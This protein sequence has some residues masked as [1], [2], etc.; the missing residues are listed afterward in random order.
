MTRSA[1]FIDEVQLRTIAAEPT[2]DPIP[3]AVVEDERVTPVV[4]QLTQNFPNPFNAHTSISYQLSTPGPVALDLYNV[5]GQL[6]RRLVDAHE[7]A[8][9]HQV[10]WDGTD[11]AGETVSSGVYFYRLQAEGRRQIRRLVLLR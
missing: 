8:G 4:F 3:T 11:D 6:V 5:S 1:I 9:V 2:P 10:T 7:M